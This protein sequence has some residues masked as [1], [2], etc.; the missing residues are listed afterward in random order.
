[1]IIVIDQEQLG[2][3]R[4]SIKQPFSGRIEPPLAHNRAEPRV[5]LVGSIRRGLEFRL[6]GRCGCSIR[7]GGPPTNP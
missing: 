6:C 7:I 1:M 3:Q 4:D 5:S 2:A